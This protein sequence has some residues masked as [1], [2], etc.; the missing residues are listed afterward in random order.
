MTQWPTTADMTA[1]FRL[2]TTIAWLVL[3]AKM[4]YS[5]VLDIPLTPL[6]VVPLVF[7]SIVMMLVWATELEAR[8]QG[9]EF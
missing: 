4:L 3:S 2:V 7:T 6:V 5:V 8:A 9:R 1:L